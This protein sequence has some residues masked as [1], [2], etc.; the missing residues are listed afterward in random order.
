[1]LNYSVAEL[2]ISIN[3]FIGKINLF[4]RKHKRKSPKTCRKE[5]YFIYLQA[6][7]KHNLFE[8]PSCDLSKTFKLEEGKL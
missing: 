6:D 7:L 5:K 2:R 1:M 3:P 8:F 4:S